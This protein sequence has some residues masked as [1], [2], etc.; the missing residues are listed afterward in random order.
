MEIK[1]A[2]IKEKFYES[3]QKNSSIIKCPWHEEVTASLLADHYK[4]TFFCLS[5]GAEGILV[6]GANEGFVALQR[7]DI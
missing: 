7:E 2:K 5:C 6:E 3:N 4:G 1:V